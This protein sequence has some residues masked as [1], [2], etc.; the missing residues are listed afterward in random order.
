MREWLQ[1]AKQLL[2]WLTQSPRRSLSQ[3]L[4]PPP[5]PDAGKSKAELFYDVMMRRLDNQSRASDALAQKTAT[6]LTVPSLAITFLATLLVA[7]RDGLS[8]SWWVVILVGFGLYVVSLVVLFFAYRPIRFLDGPYRRQIG[9]NVRDPQF[10]VEDMYYSIAYFISEDTLLGNDTLIRRQGV[11]LNV[12][13][14]LALAAIITLLLTIV[15]NLPNHM[16]TGGIP[17][18]PVPTP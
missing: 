3:T 8:R 16:V 6:W 9:A 5:V 15:F 7:E 18:T 13:V 17:S 1:V 12:G 2:L 10:T 14:L 4:P 11:V